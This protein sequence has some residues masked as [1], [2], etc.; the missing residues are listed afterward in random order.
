MEGDGGRVCGMSGATG[1]RARDVSLFEMKPL[2]LL[3][4]LFI[5]LWLCSSPHGY[6]GD[7]PW[8]MSLKLLPTAEEIEREKRTSF[9]LANTDCT[10]LDKS[11][12]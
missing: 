4:L 3:F 1:Y 8:P 2:F 9:R 11:R 12:V 6:T 7:L 5:L 10:T